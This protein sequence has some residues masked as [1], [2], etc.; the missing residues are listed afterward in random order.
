MGAASG[1]LDAGVF[2]VGLVLGIWGFAEVYPA[3]YDFAWS[4][5]LG[6][7]TL[8]GLLGL[9]S[10]IVAILVAGMALGLFSLAAIA[11][12]KFSSRSIDIKH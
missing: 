3:I 9:P 7:L 12:K 10:W 6:I 11:E 8:P 4:G 1:R 5:D 2:M